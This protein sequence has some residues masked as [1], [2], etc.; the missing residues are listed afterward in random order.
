[1]CLRDSSARF[2][3][4][5]QENSAVT[6]LVDVMQQ[7]GY[8]AHIDAIGNAVGTIGSGSREILLLG[9]IDTVSGEIA[10]RQENNN[11]FGRG[12]V[13]AKG[14][15]ASF[16]CAGAAATYSPGLA[17]YGDWCGRRRR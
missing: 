11:L 9:H 17:N 1:M 15:L 5:G 7:M 2:S 6:Y 14:P 10:V 13:D 3:P 16:V 4:T 8:Q 12:A